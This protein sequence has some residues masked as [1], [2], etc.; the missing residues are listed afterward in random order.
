M[1]VTTL[2]DE[3]ETGRSLGFAGLATSSVRGHYSTKYSKDG[4]GHQRPSSD[5]CMHR[6]MHIPSCNLIYPHIPSYTLMH[7]DHNYKHQTSSSAYEM[8]FSLP[9]V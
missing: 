3:M 6:N 8:K 2:L 5:L 9:Y 1:P 7:I 4:A